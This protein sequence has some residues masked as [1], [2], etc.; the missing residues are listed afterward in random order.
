M[1]MFPAGH[2]WPIAAY[3][4]HVTD[5]TRSG[6]PEDFRTAVQ[7]M[8]RLPPCPDLSHMETLDAE[9]HGWGGFGDDDEILVLEPYV[10]LV[11]RSFI[12]RIP[13]TT[14]RAMVDAES[15]KWRD[16]RDV[17]RVPAAIK[18]EIKERVQT[19][20]MEA[21]IPS[22]RQIAL[23]IDQRASRFYVLAHGGGLDGIETQVRYLL[24]RAYGGRAE[25][26][27]ITFQNAIHEMFPSDAA[28]ASLSRDFMRY[29][30]SK[31]GQTLHIGN[32]S[33]LFVELPES[34]DMALGA[35][36]R[37]SVT[38][39]DETE[40]LLEERGNDEE[41]LIRRAAFN[42]RD[43]AGEWTLK[44]GSD[45][46]LLRATMP[47]PGVAED[48]EGEVFIRVASCVRAQ[49][50]L[51]TLIHAFVIEE[52]EPQMDARAQRPLFIGAI[53]GLAA[54]V[55]WA[56]LPDGDEQPA[57]FVHDVPEQVAM[58][59]TRAAPNV[60]DLRQAAAGASDEDL[61]EAL[62][63]RALELEGAP[64]ETPSSALRF[65]PDLSE[66]I[67][68]RPTPAPASDYAASAPAVQ[69]VA[70][71]EV[72]APSI[73]DVQPSP[74]PLDLS[75]PQ[76]L[77]ADIV[78]TWDSPGD[79]PDPVPVPGGRPIRVGIPQWKQAIDA[80]RKADPAEVN[81]GW[82]SRKTPVAREKAKVIIDTMRKRGLLPAAAPDGGEA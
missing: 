23:F 46:T 18:R 36:G 47:S 72:D 55:R 62:K 73:D 59:F 79:P 1:P 15:K 37:M 28:P 42:V 7:S 68:P 76:P 30:T 66:D 24:D 25:V 4:F 29:V 12:K 11:R 32:V 40:R 38:G 67:Q 65:S 21:T 58:S 82:L 16:E 50:M 70:P 71:P 20:L 41:T 43:D 48:D 39:E 63:A 74:E 78:Y 35:S 64:D 52:V 80:V 57:A 69:P 77:V 51:E 54:D 17:Q 34:V 61:L 33:P 26:R 45:G 13:P 44:V 6:S 19:K 53:G 2:S 31:W 22:V 49:E 81:P 8:R 14:L 5:P 10:V 3:R 27:L 56:Q 60:D 75:E 9:Q